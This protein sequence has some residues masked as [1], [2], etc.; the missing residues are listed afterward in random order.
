MKFAVYSLDLFGIP[1]SMNHNFYY[2]FVGCCILV[3]A[4]NEPQP[5]ILTEYVPAKWLQVTNKNSMC[6]SLSI[7]IKVLN[8]F[9]LRIWT[10]LPFYIA[11]LQIIK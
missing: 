4:N 6:F 9:E 8:A 1:I 10:F 7:S 11:H 3:S 5:C 2:I